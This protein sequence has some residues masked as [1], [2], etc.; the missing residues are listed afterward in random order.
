[1]KIVSNLF[2]PKGLL[3]GYGAVGALIDAGLALYAIIRIHQGNS[4]IHL[5]GIVGADIHAYTATH[6]FILVYKRWH[7]FTSE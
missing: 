6:A 3:H 4:T 5:D 2:P 7:I 1:M